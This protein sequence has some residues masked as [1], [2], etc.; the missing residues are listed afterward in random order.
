MRI[1][2]GF[3]LI[4]GSCIIVSSAQA[5]QCV[6]PNTIANGQVADATEV[7]DNFNAVATCVEDTRDNA[8]THEGAPQTGEIAVFA[9]PTGVTGGDL[10]GDVTTSGGTATALS[11]TTVVPGTYTNSTITVDKKG[12]ITSA[13]SGALSGGGASLASKYVVANAGDNFIDVKLDADDGYAYRIIVKGEP[14]S[15]SRLF[16]RVSSDNGTTF[17]AGTSDYKYYDIGAASAID[18]TSRRTILSGRNTI[19]SFDLAGMNN[20]NN[21]RIALTGTLFSVATGIQ[22]VIR[23]VGGHNNGLAAGNFNAFRIYAQNGNMDGFAIYV[24]RVF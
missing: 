8:V 15:D 10:T 19:I 4:I 9:S 1:V 16:F 11:D 17:H 6:V 2:F 13:D 5:Q 12:R 21:E 24:E 18:L 14:S 7:M 3:S 22:N 23:A 20:Q